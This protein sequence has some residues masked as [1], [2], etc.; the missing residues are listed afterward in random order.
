MSP[1]ERMGA[2]PQLDSN[3]RPSC[4][5]HPRPSPSTVV[6][7]PDAM[8]SCPFRT[9]ARSIMADILSSSAA[10]EERTV[11]YGAFVIS[12]DFELLW[13]VRDRR[14]A[15]DYGMNI[16]GVRDVVPAL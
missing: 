9:L 6:R 3:S 10:V 1:H 14:T 12:L 2:N 13:G 5:R 15:A 4:N 8:K 16:R 11:R 7:A